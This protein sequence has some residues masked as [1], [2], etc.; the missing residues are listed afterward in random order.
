MFGRA[1]ALKKCGDRGGRPKWANQ[2]TRADV[3][4]KFERCSC[5]E[6]S[7][8]TTLQT[9]F[10]IEPQFGGKTSMMRR[11]RVRAEKLAQVMRDALSHP[12]RVHE[13]QRRPVRLN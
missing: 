9:I 8:L 6:R 3:D 1:A 10:G 2:A 11:D 7:Q 12:P 5:N 4:P 13:N